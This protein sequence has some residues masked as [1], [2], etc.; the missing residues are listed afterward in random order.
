MKK[1][2]PKEILQQFQNGLKELPDL[3]N[4]QEKKIFLQLQ[5]Y[6]LLY[7]TPEGMF[8]ITR[9]GETALKGDI[10]KRLSIER[11]EE[12]LIK[13]SF[14]QNSRQELIFFV[15]VLFFILLVIAVLVF[16]EW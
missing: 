11:F 4:E 13:D 14:K 9:K 15:V 8:K 10:E 7:V 5:K 1:N 12:R 2:L 3:K 16:N 6:N